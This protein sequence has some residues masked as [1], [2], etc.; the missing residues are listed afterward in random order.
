MWYVL[1]ARHFVHPV[2]WVASTSV[3]VYAFIEV[4]FGAYLFY[5]GRKVQRPTPASTDRL[6]TISDM[7]LRTLLAGRGFTPSPRGR[8][9]AL[10]GAAIRDAQGRARA[11]SAASASASG[12]AY[13]SAVKTP[14]SPGWFPHKMNLGLASPQ[15]RRRTP[16]SGDAGDDSSLD[17][18]SAGAKHEEKEEKEIDELFDE[19]GEPRKLD[20]D[21][22]RAVEF[23]EHI[24]M[25]WV[26][27]G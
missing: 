4:A 14:L 27:G 2:A 10:S 3:T 7:F 15:I 19:Y 21:D 11:Y 22:P 1:V 17:Y 24:R 13:G 26:C 23:R 8:A 12:G 16:L 20:A 18:L 6:D 5:L 9:R 25:W